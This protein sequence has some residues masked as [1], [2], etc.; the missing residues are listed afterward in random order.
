MRPE[1]EN[2]YVENMGCFTHS[3]QR[4]VY[5]MREGEERLVGVWYFTNGDNPPPAPLIQAIENRADYILI[6]F[7]GNV[8]QIRL[9]NA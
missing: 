1:L 9:D 7:A 2:G 8:A 5:A 4:G 6:R 3:S